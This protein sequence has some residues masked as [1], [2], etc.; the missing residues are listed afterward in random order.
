MIPRSLPTPRDS[1]SARRASNRRPPLPTNRPN[2]ELPGDRRSLQSAAVAVGVA[3]LRLGWHGDGAAE[4]LS[5]SD[6]A[7]ASWGLRASGE[8]CGSGGGCWVGGAD[9][10]FVLGEEIAGRREESGRHTIM[11]WIPVVVVARGQP[12]QSTALYT[13][14]L[15][16]GGQQPA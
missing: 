8:S 13:V 9:L 10:G 4:G 14:L 6:G 12:W 3:E 1:R 5:R 16:A 15:L 11:Q 7:G 2:T